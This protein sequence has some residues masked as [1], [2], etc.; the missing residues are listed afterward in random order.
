MASDAAKLFL[1]NQQAGT[2]PA[3]SLIATV[4]SFDVP[5][6]G[7]DN[8]ESGFDHVRAGQ[9]HPQLLRNVKPMNSQSFFQT[10]SQTACR[11]RIQVHQL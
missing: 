9:R 1:R 8:R 6:N 10:F 5:A 4:P 3:F 7:F 2:D 11:T